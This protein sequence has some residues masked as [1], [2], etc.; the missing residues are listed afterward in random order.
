VGETGIKERNMLH[1]KLSPATER[2]FHKILAYYQNH[3]FLAQKIIDTEIRELRDSIGNISEEL[4]MFEKK[5]QISSEDFYRKFE[6]GEYDDREDYMIWAGSYEMLV[7]NQ[8]KLEDL[9]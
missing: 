9:R 1:I 8:K 2:K 5:Y 6:N 4:M 7:K 3:D